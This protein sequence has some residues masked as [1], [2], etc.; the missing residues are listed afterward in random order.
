MNTMLSVPV[1]LVWEIADVGPRTD[2]RSS[3]FEHFGAVKRYK[4]NGR[5]RAN[6]REVGF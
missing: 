6:G 5:V 1:V 3:A 4:W 2:E